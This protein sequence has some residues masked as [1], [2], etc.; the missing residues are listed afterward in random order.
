[1]IWKVFK[2]L[3]LCKVIFKENLAIIVVRIKSTIPP[4]AAITFVAIPK[5]SFIKS[6]IISIGS[7]EKSVIYNK[8]EGL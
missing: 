5:K 7:V 8:E 1:M 6:F 4:K 2:W 3:Q